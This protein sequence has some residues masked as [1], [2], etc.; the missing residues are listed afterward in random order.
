MSK[1]VVEVKIS[2]EGN[3]LEGPYKNPIHK[4]QDLFA[5]GII[6]A[7]PRVPLKHKVASLSSSYKT[8]SIGIKVAQFMVEPLLQCGIGSRDISFNTVSTIRFIK[9]FSQKRTY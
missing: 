6:D 9:P 2:A 4:Q 8:L 3:Q 5:Q 1:A 7:A